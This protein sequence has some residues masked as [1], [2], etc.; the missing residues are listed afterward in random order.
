MLT[1]KELGQALVAAM[2]KKGVTQA[3][4]ARHFDVKP[5]SVHDW[6]EHGR[7]SKSRIPEI[8]E[9]FS[10]VVPPE[11]WGFSPKMSK[12]VATTD[13]LPGYIR[14]KHLSPQPSMGHGA[15]LS[16]PEH[17]VQTIDVLEAWA[18]QKLGCAN[19]ERI[20]VLTAA[21]PSMRPTI[22]DQDLVFVDIG[23]RFIDTPNIYVIDV[24]GRLLLKRVMIQ[25]SGMVV[26]FSDNKAEFPDEER[27][28]LKEAQQL[29][30]VCGKVLGWWTLRQ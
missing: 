11:Y 20:R 7:I 4:V 6:M 8:V 25:A 2:K 29:I 14:L 23:H 13:P 10:D 3:D 1:K 17:I 22:Y 18:R 16:E 24:G 26:I 5:P 9:F 30:T 21:G 15:A 12:A 19:P 27:Y 28:P